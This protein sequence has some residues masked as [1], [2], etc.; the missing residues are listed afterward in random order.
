MTILDTPALAE[1][2]VLLVDDD[3]STLA[4][5]ADIVAS[6][7]ARTTQ[8]SDVGHACAAL[9]QGSF[10]L[11]LTD[12][13]LGEHELGYDVADAARRCR[14]EVPVVMLTGQPS[15]R[16]AAD[17]LRSQVRE[18][19]VKPVDPDVLIDACTRAIHNATIERRARILEGQNRVL[20]AVVPRMIEAKDPTT[21]GH[22][23]RVVHYA[24]R[25]AERC[26]VSRADRESL[27][28]AAVLHDVGKIGVPRS[29][30]CKEGP[31]DSAER[32]VIEEHPRVG[33]E[34][35]AGLEGCE[36][37]RDWVYQ[38]HERWDG[39]GY[40]NRLAGEDVALPGRILILAEVYDALAETR[41]YKPAWEI[42]RIVG[43]FREQ[44]G[45]HFDPDLAG[46]VADGLEREERRFFAPRGGMLF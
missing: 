37:A 31:L 33:Y 36:D 28:L 26:G 8:V 6:A 42:S 1:R 35:L 30:L 21:S 5:L 32:K 46:M 7:G 9:S 29:I 15:F 14:P 19:V 40:P 24:D 43:F 45:K 39:R 17:A 34:I 41:S 3:P 16:G 22:A 4:A 25:L 11:V 13:Y 27:R 2:R 38:H 44:A 18:L 12:L 20:S 10:D 23:E